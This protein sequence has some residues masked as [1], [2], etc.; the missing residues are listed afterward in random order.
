[1]HHRMLTLFAGMGGPLSPAYTQAVEVP[2]ISKL[3]FCI[4][5]EPVFYQLI[6]SVW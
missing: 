1:M 2:R 5:L 4:I 3:Y 6:V